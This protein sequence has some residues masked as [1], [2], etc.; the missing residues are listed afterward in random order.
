MNDSIMPLN[1]VWVLQMG[2]ASFRAPSE[3]PFGSD[4]FFQGWRWSL[5][6]ASALYVG[7]SPRSLAGLAASR[8]GS[9][10]FVFG[11]YGLYEK[12]DQLDNGSSNDESVS[13]DIGYLND[14]W[15]LDLN[16][17]S[18]AW[19]DADI[20]E[21]VTGSPSPDAGNEAAGATAGAT[22]AAPDAAT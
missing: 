22:D 8:D 12:Q 6:Q 9:T 17:G 1:D 19:V 3:V 16:A 4:A 18:G 7:P 21:A 15:A 10:L 5:V 14:L 13:L 2:D 11:G 20:V